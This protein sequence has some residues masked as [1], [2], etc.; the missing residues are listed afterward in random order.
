MSQT[1]GEKLRQAREARDITI[2]EVE[3]VLPKGVG[4]SPDEKAIS[5][6]S[7]GQLGAGNAGSEISANDKSKSKNK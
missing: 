3:R 1:L 6:G 2:S 7:R 4:Y 5:G